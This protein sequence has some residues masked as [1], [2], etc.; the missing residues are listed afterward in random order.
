MRKITARI[1]S[2]LIV[3]ILT[4][5][6]VHLALALSSGSS[7]LADNIYNSYTLQALQWLQGQLDLGR[8][9]THLELAV[10]EGKYFVSFP[11]LPSL[12]LLPFAGA[13]GA[14][15]PDHII[16]GFLFVLSAVYAYKLC[17][18]YDLSRDVSFFMSLFVCL[19]GNILF[20]SIRG[21]WVWF[22]AQNA[23]FL[24]TVMSFYYIRRNLA[25]SL[26]CLACAIGCRPFQ[27]IYA[28]ILLRMIFLS[29]DAKEWGGL[30]RRVCVCAIPAALLFL[31]Y[32]TLNYLR[33]HS[34]FEFGHNYL[35]E[36][37]EASNGQFSVVYIAENLRNLFRMPY[38]NEKGI[39]TFYRYNGTA[40]WLVSPIF[41]TFAI[42]SARHGFPREHLALAALHL[43]LLCAHKTMGGWHFGARY[44][45]DAL[46]AV[47][48]GLVRWLSRNHGRDDCYGDQTGRNFI[49][50]NTPLFLTGLC[51]NFAGT[52]W[53]YTRG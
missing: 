50:W 6:G 5:A 2:V 24:F 53:I 34:P 7:P 14:S 29:Q 1:D 19:G 52:I 4:V 21:G 16:A 48:F 51:V 15:T 32:L 18:S 9:Y 30:I 11:P 42:A 8:N 10:F 40:F 33:F 47:L 37:Q 38:L 20:L 23:A 46:P 41:V 26:F 22:L 25:A 17:R 45:V 3:L 35:P 44:T 36:F 31:F 49:L 13:L 12:L 39:L 43:L 28:P 27:I